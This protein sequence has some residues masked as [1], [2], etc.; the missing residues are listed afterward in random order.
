MAKIVESIITTPDEKY[1]DNYGHVTVVV[2]DTETGERQTS[3]REYDYFT[4]ESEAEANAIKDAI[5]KF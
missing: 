3:S 4:K 2:Q 1:P 5:D